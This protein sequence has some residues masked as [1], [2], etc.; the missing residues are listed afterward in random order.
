MGT[1]CTNKA[2]LIG[3]VEGGEGERRKEGR[4]ATEEKEEEKEK[5][6]GVFSSAAT[7]SA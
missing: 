4:K 3:L 2:A 1:R 5:P 7:F 6:Q